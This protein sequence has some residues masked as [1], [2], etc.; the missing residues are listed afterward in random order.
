VRHGAKIR[1]DMLTRTVTAQMAIPGDNLPADRTL[2]FRGHKVAYYE[3]GQGEPMLFLHNAGNDHHIWE[4]QIRYFSQKQRVVAVDSLGYGKSDTPKLDYSLP[5]YSDMVS[6]IVDALGLAP[7]T[8][9]AT[10]TGAAMALNYALANPQKV[11]RLI[12]FH[13][14]T[15]NTVVGGNL[16]PTVKMVSGRPLMRRIMMPLVDLMMS[17]GILHRGIIRGQYDETFQ[18]NPEFLHHLHQLYGKKGEGA[19]LINLFSNWS[20]FASLDQ[21]HPPA[22]FPPVHIF[23]GAANKVIP[24]ARGREL[25]ERLHPQT[26]DV[27]EGGGHLV[28]RE[29]PEFINRRIEELI[30]S[31]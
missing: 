26:I 7:V 23:W 28:M 13:I 5:L 2:L 8:I 24:L 6:T 17:R 1:R 29:K 19:C 16:E 14:A 25:C 4:H 31:A 12:L 9:V 22:G 18:E 21:V 27:I 15:E 10:C 20:S 3:H 30:E 11:K